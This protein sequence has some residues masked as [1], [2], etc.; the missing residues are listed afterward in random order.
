MQGEKFERIG[1]V[2]FVSLFYIFVIFIV[3]E[4]CTENSKTKST[5]KSNNRIEEDDITEEDYNI[6][7]LLPV[8]GH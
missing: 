6:E 2:V 3:W 7:D 8:R 4:G 5:S 1:Q